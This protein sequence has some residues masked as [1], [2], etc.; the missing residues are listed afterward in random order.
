MTIEQFNEIKA[1]MPTHELIEKAWAWCC[2]LAETGGKAWTM[3]LPPNKND[4]DM[5]FSELC[6]RLEYLQRRCDAAE[7]CIE[8]SPYDPDITGDQ[9]EAH[10]KWEAIKSETP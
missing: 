6:R 8:M 10:Q 1:A 3:S 7:L 4:P 2:K 9:I 5:I